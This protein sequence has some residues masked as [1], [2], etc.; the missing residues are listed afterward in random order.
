MSDL[1][2]FYPEEHELHVSEGHPE[3]PERVEAIR[4]ALERVG[5]WDQVAF[6]QPFDIPDEI[7]FSI[8]TRDHTQRLEQAGARGGYIDGDTYL[9]EA[10][11]RLAL[12]A[13]GGGIAVA[14][15]VY[16][17]RARRGLALTRP[18]GHHATQGQAMGFC[19]LNNIA[20]AAEYLLQTTDAERMAILDIDLHH[21]NGTQDIFFSRGDVFFCSIHQYPLYPMTGQFN[22]TG[23][24]DGE[25]TN[26]NIPFPPYAGDNARASALEEVILPL[27]TQFVPDMLLVSVGFDAHW[28]DPLG[29]QLATANGYAQLMMT[30][31]TFA[32]SHCEG[33]LAVFL[34]GGYDI[35]AGAASCLAMT[36]AMV[37]EK[38]EDEIGPGPIP[39][40]DYWKSRLQQ[41]KQHWQNHMS[42]SGVND[43]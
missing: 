16:Q 5:I 32:E 42:G 6:V 22:E 36:Q 2:I 8:H 12:N 19:L 20:L 13:A 33:R 14:D 21:G 31:T 1:V 29:H 10:S 23:Y 4:S 28:R 41:V 24:A 30:L 15:E 39:E 11:W 38:W 37:G 17:R 35:E 9:T 7:L 27:L 40:D 18:P 25:W 3:R 34:E 26:L 43:D